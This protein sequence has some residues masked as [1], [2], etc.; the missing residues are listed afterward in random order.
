MAPAS[1]FEQLGV[2]VWGVEDRSRQEGKL[3]LVTNVRPTKPGDSVKLG[4]VF[5]GGPG[6]SSAPGDNFSTIGHPAAD[7]SRQLTSKWHPRFQPVFQHQ[8]DAEAASFKMSTASPEGV[9]DWTKS[10]RVT[11]MGNAVHCMTPAGGVG[12]STAP[13]DAAFLGRLL[14]Q[15]GGWRNGITEG[16][17]KE[18]RI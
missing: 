17:E 3:A 13:R 15:G 6:T 9:P 4:W 16:Y 11:V 8:N 10:P 7:V 1:S 14:R 2:G 5:V 12:A 18:M